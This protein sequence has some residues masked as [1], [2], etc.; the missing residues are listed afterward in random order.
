M[1]AVISMSEI[2]A[3]AAALGGL[4][5]TWLR[6]NCGCADCRDPHSGQRLVSI[7]DQ[8]ERVWIAAVTAAS[9]SITLAFGPDGHEA[10]YQESWIA[11]QQTEQPDPRTEDARLLWTAS[12]FVGQI[13]A[14]CWPRYLADDGHRAA[15]LDRLLRTGFVLIRDVPAEPGGVLSAAET[16]GFVRETNY[17]RLFDVR[18][19]ATPANLAF[20]GLPIAPHTDNPFAY[21][22][23]AAELTATRPMIGLDPRGRIREVRFNNRSMQ[24]LRPWPGGRPGEVAERAVAFY[25]AHRA[26]AEILARP[27]LML[28]FR[29][30]PG[31]CVMFDNTLILHARTGF[32]ATGNR[33]LQGCCADLDGVASSRRYRND[34]ASQR[35]S[36]SLAHNGETKD[37]S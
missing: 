9:G 2:E 30:G 17:G 6:D 7:T 3:G 5:A 12:D 31:D 18:V 29:L 28:T 20:T 36:G 33:H 23:A 10:V 26:F 4:P 14:A 19:E 22:D 24:P 15:S 25:A 34:Q 8:P 16:M 13:P 1:T 32:A 21:S 37:G 27:E 11:G 35:V